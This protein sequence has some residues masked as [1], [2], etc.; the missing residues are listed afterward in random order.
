[1]LMTL[2]FGAAS[3]EVDIISNFQCGCRGTLVGAVGPYAVFFPLFV[4]AG[5]R[6]SAKVQSNQN[7]AATVNAA[8]FLMGGTSDIGLPVF[9]ACDTYGANTA[10]ST[11]TDHTS[12]NSGSESTPATIG[13]TTREYKAISL[14]LGGT[15][16]SMANAAY[17]WY[18]SLN[19]TKLATWISSTTTSETI[20]GPHPAQPLYTPIASGTALQISGECSTTAEAV[21]VTFLCWY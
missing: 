1:M 16:N 3:S 20:A 5:T 8:I 7:F 17:Y 19:S 12:G 2:A 9:N 10:T 4:P 11:G 18:L 6:V 15:D 21:D 14:M 13:T